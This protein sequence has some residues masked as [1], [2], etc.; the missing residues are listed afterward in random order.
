MSHFFLNVA[1][2]HWM[3]GA[4]RFEMTWWSHLEETLSMGWLTEV[5]MWLKPT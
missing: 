3:I 1:L 5:A 4:Q 2:H